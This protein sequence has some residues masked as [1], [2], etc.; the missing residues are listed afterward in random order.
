MSGSA[1]VEDPASLTKERLKS[2]LL[3]HKVALPTGEQKKDVYVKLYLKHVTPKRSG[4]R[5]RAG[6]RADFSS[7]EEEQQPP[8]ASPNRKSTRKTVVQVTPVKETVTITEIIEEKDITKMSDMELLKLLSQYGLNSGPIIATTRK[9]YESKLMKAMKEGTPATN[10]K[11]VEEAYS[12]DDDENNGKEAAEAKDKEVKEPKG[13][14]IQTPLASRSTRSAKVKVTKETTTTTMTTTSTMSKRSLKN[15][16]EP[17]I[18][19]MSSPKGINATRRRPLHSSAEPSARGEDLLVRRETVTVTSAAPA[20]ARANAQLAPAKPVRATDSGTATRAV[21][22]RRFPVWLRVL[23]VLA[24]VVFLALVY[25]NME[26]NEPK[27]TPPKDSRD[28]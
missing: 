15:F 7:D 17:S 5:A 20:Y 2:E 24:L 3:A 18:E 11:A 13:N 16:K 22:H 26:S 9:V 1:V 14:S 10:T 23:L 12:D 4:V 19:V 27:P 28:V 8:R 21:A 6:L 25:A